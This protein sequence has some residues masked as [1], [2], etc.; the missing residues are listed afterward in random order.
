MG[1]GST[2]PPRWAMGVDAATLRI[3]MKFRM[4]GPFEAVADDDRLVSVGSR[5]QE[6]CLLGGR[7]M[8]AGLLVSRGRLLALLWDGRPPGAPPGTI[9]ACVARP[10]RALAPYGVHIST[11]HDG[12][13]LDPDRH[14]IDTEEF[15]DL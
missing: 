3:A 7:R 12:Y 2:V 1:G 4:L 5:R 10:R 15:V 6:R 13:A 9:H 14:V 8:A 11:R